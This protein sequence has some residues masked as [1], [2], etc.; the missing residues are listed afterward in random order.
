MFNPTVFTIKN[1][2]TTY[3]YSAIVLKVKP[4][5]DKKIL[6]SRFHQYNPIE[7][8]SDFSIF[9]DKL[10]STHEDNLRDC[11]ADVKCR[12]YIQELQKNGFIF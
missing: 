3:Q 6:F 11:L 12:S 5:A 4:T 7:R 1:L 9:Q 10:P 2:S 8:A